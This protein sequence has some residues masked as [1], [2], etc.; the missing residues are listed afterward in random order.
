M[1]EVLHV[2]PE[3]LG[4]IAHEVRKD[5]WCRPRPNEDGIYVHRRMRASQWFEDHPQGFK[6]TE[7][8]R[9]RDRM[10]EFLIIRSAS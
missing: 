6:K 9:I 8:I 1:S 2:V 3:F 4:D 7:S 5:C 10:K